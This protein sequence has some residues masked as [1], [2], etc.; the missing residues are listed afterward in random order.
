MAHSSN[1]Y[2]D[3]PIHQQSVTDLIGEASLFQSVPD[4]WFVVL[5]DIKGSTENVR[6]GNQQ[7]INLI[8]SGSV[9]AA[10][11]IAHEAH[12]EIPFFFGG[13]GATVLAPS[14]IHASL[15][16]ALSEHQENTEN[17]FGLSLRVGSMRVA[18]LY[19]ADQHLAIAKA[20]RCPAFSMPLILGNGLAFAENKIKSNDDSSS[21]ESGR[22]HELNLD[23][24]ECR[25]DKVYPPGD[26]DEVICLLA[27]SN[28]EAQMSVNFQAVLKCVEEI[29]GDSQ[30]RNPISQE[31]LALKP[32]L[33]RISTEMR[34]KTGGFDWHYLLENWFRTLIGPGYFRFTEEGRAYVESLPKLADTL[35]M[36][37][38]VNTVISGSPD[39][40]IQLLTKLGNLENAGS[41]TFGYDV[42]KASVMSCYVRDRHDQ[43]IHFVD[44]ENGGY[45][46]AA[47]MLKEK[48]KGLRN[49]P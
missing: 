22:A 12:I 3:L 34:C 15:L 20:A 45:T 27:V 25:W 33:G 4:D 41:I 49:T 42:S 46:N 40:R 9:I 7:Q 14:S 38:R 8:A 2:S 24:M 1:F 48:L 36:D 11:N 31:K 30:Q 29:Y 6:R 43:H 26:A 16:D 5:T 18:D 13:D 35:V 17:N 32:S 10:L 21:N 37:G 19:E 23:G 28:S 39:Q 47:I 44:G